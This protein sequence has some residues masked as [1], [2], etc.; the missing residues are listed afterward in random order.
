MHNNI[1]NDIAIIGMVT[2]LVGIFIPIAAPI[3]LILSIINYKNCKKIRNNN[4]EFDNEDSQK[5]QNYALVGII[6]GG[7]ISIIWAIL[8][9]FWIGTFAIIFHQS[10]QGIEGVTNSINVVVWYL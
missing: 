1:Q 8:L 3:G 4:V 5:Y 6:A 10:F 2:A 7:V 9:I